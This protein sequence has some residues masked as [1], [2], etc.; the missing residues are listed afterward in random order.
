MSDPQHSAANQ[1][2]I[3]KDRAEALVRSGIG[4]HYHDLS[5][6]LSACH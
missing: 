3:D 1:Q 6:L 5:L 4:R 2:A